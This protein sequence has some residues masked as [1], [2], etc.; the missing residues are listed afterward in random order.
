MNIQIEELIKLLPGKYQEACYETKAIERK[1]TVQTP[2]ELLVMDL[3][4]LYGASLVET[5]QMAEMN[6]TGK[7]SDVAFMKRF[8]KS[9]DWFQ[10]ITGNILPEEMSR[11][12][13]PE[14]L[15]PYNV[16]ARDASD[17]YTKGAVKQA[18]HLHY[19]VD[20]FFFNCRQFKITEEKTGGNFSL[21]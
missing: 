8:I 7:M 12:Q 5:S 6:G 14:K 17:V 20:L 9:K 18:W 10:W 4:Y 15:D 13:K 1:R 19:P 16:V 2:E 21:S 11:Y 3:Y